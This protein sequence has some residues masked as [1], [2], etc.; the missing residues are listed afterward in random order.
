MCKKKDKLNNTKHTTMIK[1]IS[2]TKRKNEFSGGY[3]NNY[4]FL[5]ETEKY[6]SSTGKKYKLK[7]F[8]YI[9][10]DVKMSEP[11][12][13]I[14]TNVDL[15]WVETKVFKGNKSL[16]EGSGIPGNI[17]KAKKWL[18]KETNEERIINGKGYRHKS[19]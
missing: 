6:T 17:K 14:N 7:T 3:N 2:K 13:T 8:G 12:F 5:L 15:Y 16:I 4:C 9:T 19:T 18:N 10:Q 1:L 11:N